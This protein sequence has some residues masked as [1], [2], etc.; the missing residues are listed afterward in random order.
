MSENDL[1]T[2]KMMKF[3]MPVDYRAQNF[4]FEKM[5]ESKFVTTYVRDISS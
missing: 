4:F 3:D 1:L 2:R 5:R